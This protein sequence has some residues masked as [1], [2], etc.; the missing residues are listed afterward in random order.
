MFEVVFAAV[1]SELLVRG[2][3]GLYS[4]LHK[5]C[6]LYTLSYDAI[7]IEAVRRCCDQYNSC[8]LIE[9]QLWRE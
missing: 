6:S 1:L 7:V 5:A 4:T 8:C 3:S 2:F 9:T